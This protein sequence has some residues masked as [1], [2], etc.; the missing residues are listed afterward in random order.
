MS[1]INNIKFSRLLFTRE[2]SED[3]LLEGD[4]NFNGSNLLVLNTSMPSYNEYIVNFSDEGSDVLNST[5]PFSSELDNPAPN[6]DVQ[7]AVAMKFCDL[8]TGTYSS[9]KSNVRIKGSQCPPPGAPAEVGDPI[10]KLD[11]YGIQIN[12]IEMVDLG[13]ETEVTVTTENMDGGSTGYRII[14][15]V[16]HIID[17]PSGPV[18]TWAFE[19]QEGHETDTNN[20][21]QINF[22]EMTAEVG[23]PILFYAEGTDPSDVHESD[24]LLWMQQ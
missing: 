17:T 19:I 9:L 18:R 23:L 7:N 1:E 12:T 22:D 20:T 24:A 14:N 2:S 5:I 21:F 16:E 13:G 15:N 11:N 8:G 4:F 6:P 3:F 10:G